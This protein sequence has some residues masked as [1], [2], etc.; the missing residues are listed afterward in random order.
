MGV[1]RCVHSQPASYLLSMSIKTRE[2]S[3]TNHMEEA[4][5][6]A[7]PVYN[8]DVRVERRVSRFITN[9]QV[10]GIAISESIKKK[11]GSGVSSVLDIF[12]GR[13]GRRHSSLSQAPPGAIWS[14]KWRRFR[15]SGGIKF[16]PLLPNPAVANRR[17]LMLFIARK[18]SKEVPNP[19][20]G[21]PRR[22]KH[23]FT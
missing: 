7:V 13:T 5:V 20:P 16:P 3:S 17:I 10:G 22:L 14:W 6:R 12:W 4:W 2:L 8:I 19:S 23:R 9:F 18:S 11:G 1:Q 21:I 15:W